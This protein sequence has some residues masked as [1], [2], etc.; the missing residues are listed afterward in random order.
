MKILKEALSL[1]LDSTCSPNANG[2]SSGG[3]RAGWGREGA[4]KGEYLKI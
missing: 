4:G 3:I 2:V 1:L